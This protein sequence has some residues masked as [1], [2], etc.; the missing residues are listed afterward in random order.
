[1]V[2]QHHVRV[3]HSILHETRLLETL[4]P[5]AWPADADGGDAR[6]PRELLRALIIATDI[7]SHREHVAT[8]T[9]RLGY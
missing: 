4:L 3:L 8:F 7:A 9:V 1:M 6:S 2:E 5:R